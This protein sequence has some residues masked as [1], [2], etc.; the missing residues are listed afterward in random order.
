[1]QQTGQ[2]NI[3]EIH[4]DLSFNLE[5]QPQRNCGQYKHNE[6]PDCDRGVA[7]LQHSAGGEEQPEYTGEPLAPPDTF[8]SVEYFKGE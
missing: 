4:T 7:E 2:C 1:M 6:G 3:T 8:D 5:I